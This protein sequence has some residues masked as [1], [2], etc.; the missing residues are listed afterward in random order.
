MVTPSF[1]MVRLPQTVPLVFLD[2]SV[3][4]HSADRLIRGR[5][6]KKT[7]KWGD[8]AVTMDVTQSVEVYP[9]A[10][11]SPTLAEEVRFL[12]LIADL[13]KT[14]RIRLTTHFE[15]D[16]EFGGLPNTDDPRGRLYGA[17]VERGPDPF[18]YSRIVAGWQ[19]SSAGRDLQFEFVRGIRFPRFLELKRAVGANETSRHYKNQLLDAFH[20]LCAEAATADF[21]LTTD[22]KLVRHVSG[23]KS[24]PPS[25]NVL[26]P[27]RL[28]KALIARRALR[29]RDVAYYF[30]R[31]IKG[32]RRPP[33]DSAAEELVA[34]GKRLERQGY[35]DKR[36]D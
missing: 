3:L 34:L 35:F 8:M 10:R 17:P 26:T 13:A 33:S 14:G 31:T 7:V 29:L 22:M 11:V 9:N 18:P 1:T 12:P 30:I 6:H 36:S 20:I 28:V 32:R 2:T 15:V 24:H 19:E 25:C 16:W 5:V 21:F 4:K 27:A 23:H